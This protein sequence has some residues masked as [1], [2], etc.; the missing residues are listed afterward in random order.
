MQPFDALT[1]RAV[2]QEAKPLLLNRKVD[3]IVQLARDE[4][5]LSM[6]SKGGTV[7]LFLSAQS[8]YGRMCLVASPATGESQEKSSLDRQTTERYQSKHGSGP[9]PNFCLTLRK[10]LIGATLVGIEQLPGE[11]IID[12]IFSATDEVGTTSL[13]ILTAE[14]MGRHSNL[15]FWD[16]ASEKIVTSSHA[17]TKDMSRQREVLPN[18]K[19]ERPPGQD[20]PSIFS[21]SQADLARKLQELKETWNSNPAPAPVAGSEEIQTK[22]HGRNGTEG[23]DEAGTKPAVVTLE[24]WLLSSFTGL[25][26]HLSEE[27][28]IAT[29]MNSM[30]SDSLNDARLEESVWQRVSAL[31]QHT[32]SKAASK[33]DLSRYTVLGWYPDLES[34]DW[35]MFPSVNDM[36]EN[37]F[38]SLEAREHFI[39]LREKIK[40]EIGSESTKLESR[41]QV[42]E[43]HLSADDE[44]LRL[45]KSGDLVL[46]SLSQISPGQTDLKVND[47]T[48]DNGDEITI[49]LNPNLSSVQNAQVYYR[50]YAK[51]RSRQGAAQSTVNEVTARLSYL[52]QLRTSC[53]SA[54]DINELRKVK[55]TLSGRKP[56]TERPRGDSKPPHQQQR[57][58]GG[59]N[60]ML[61]LTSSDGWTVFVGRNRMENDHLLNKVA[62]PND[63]WLHVLGQGGAH[64]L[65]RVPSNKQEPPKTTIIEA[66]HIAARLSK[67]GTGTKVRVVYTQCKHVK[68]IDSTKSGLVK[69]E[70][71]KTIEVDTAKPM[72]KLMKKLFN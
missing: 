54:T 34:A 37:Y 64:V 55:E 25:G 68:K 63:I 16:K 19:Y 23:G 57:P 47:W 53:D 27:V 65:I 33:K 14:I 10:Y 1:I 72:P 28:V 48:K 50:Q 70:N 49:K 30:L 46:T 29:G 35:T 56:Q 9:P 38:R 4:V 6:R 40:A 62:N 59:G 44:L 5:L 71:E 42:A 17:V 7:C 61:S 39:Q 11:R 24:Q 51:L 45:K 13:K 18:L 20:R 43:D 52:G 36:V 58:K 67:A 3:K 21:V 22:R 26:K 15:I 2:L 12:F 8:V 31:Q 32:H 60:K 66:A 69:Y 41:K